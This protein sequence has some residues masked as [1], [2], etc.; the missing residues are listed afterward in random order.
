MV[1]RLPKGARL[2]PFRINTCKSVSKQMTLIPFRINTYEKH[3]GEGGRR[4]LRNSHNPVLAEGV[5][6]R[7]FLQFV[8]A[9][10]APASQK[11][12]EAQLPRLQLLIG[13]KK[14]FQEVL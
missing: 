12:Q 4:N 13:R 8:Q 9:V 1:H 2:S 10:H 11:R 5:A 6:A 14:I 7:E 3:R